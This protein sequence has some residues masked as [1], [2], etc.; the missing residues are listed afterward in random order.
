MESAISS[1]SLPRYAT[2][3]KARSAQAFSGS[4]RNRR[5]RGD[6]ETQSNL[7]GPIKAF[8]EGASAYEQGTPSRL[9]QKIQSQASELTVEQCKE[10]LMSFLEEI[11]TIVDISSIEVQ[12]CIQLL[13]T[14]Y[15]IEIVGKEPKKPSDWARLE[16]MAPNCY[17][18]CDECPKMNAFLQ[19]PQLQRHNLSSPST[20]H[21]GSRYHYLKYFEFDKVDNKVVAVAKTLK[22]WEEQHQE[23]KSRASDALEAL[24]KLPQASLKHCLNHR[25]DEVMNLRMV[26]LIDDSH[27]STNQGQLH[28]ETKSIVP[29]KRPQ[30]D[31]SRPT[32]EG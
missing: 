19:D 20:Y 31:G 1:F 11:I 14:T 16:E 18:D 12:E 29:Q 22:W 9:L 32:E 4:L 8:Y 17:Q 3:I 21:L 2:Y 27:E 13:V 10:F 30:D 7:G 5:R 26:K 23:W 6:K 15:I 28:H 24:R 25:Y